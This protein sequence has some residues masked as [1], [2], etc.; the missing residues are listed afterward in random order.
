[1]ALWDVKADPERTGVFF[2]WWNWGC[3]CTSM[4]WPHF[5][6]R[7][8]RVPGLDPASCLQLL[9]IME[10]KLTNKTRFASSCRLHVEIGWGR[11][12]SGHPVCLA[13]TRKP[14]RQSANR[15]TPIR[16][17]W[18]PNSGVDGCWI[19]LETISMNK[20]LII[21]IR[22]SFVSARPWPLLIGRPLMLNPNLF[23]IW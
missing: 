6:W 19:I 11:G 5:W 16:V 21:T 23:R 14:A 12:L 15:Q 4:E 2:E 8:E 22:P 10:N 9:R 7:P 1:L 3:D 20:P 13:R 17:P 18:H